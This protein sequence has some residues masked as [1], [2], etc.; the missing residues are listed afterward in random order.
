MET[1]FPPSNLEFGWNG[2]FQMGGFCIPRH[3]SRPVNAPTNFSPNLR[4]PGA[5]NMSFVD[6][7]VEQ[8]KLERLWR[9]TWHRNYK[10]LPK[11]PGLP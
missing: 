6:G 5:I 1:D 2:S 11:R 10:A 8:V 4:L 3:G 7:H 9:L